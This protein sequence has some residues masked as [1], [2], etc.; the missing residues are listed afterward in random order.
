MEINETEN[1]RSN[2]FPALYTGICAPCWEVEIT[3]ALSNLH[4]W[5][6]FPK[7]VC[8]AGI[9]NLRFVRMAIRC[10]EFACN[11]LRCLKIGSIHGTEI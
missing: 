7:L 11:G 4:S 5:R 10:T 9:L 1:H 6:E 2:P 3:Y 8:G